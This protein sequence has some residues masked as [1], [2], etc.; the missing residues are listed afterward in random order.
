VRDKIKKV[1][2]LGKFG[3]N[4]GELDVDALSLWGLQLY[5]TN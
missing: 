4:Y 1:D 3:E 5:Q 2:Y